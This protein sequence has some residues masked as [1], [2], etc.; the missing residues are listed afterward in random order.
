MKILQ[1]EKKKIIAEFLQL[2]QTKRYALYSIK[3]GICARYENNLSHGKYIFWNQTKQTLVSFVIFGMILFTRI[4]CARQMMTLGIFVLLVPGCLY[5]QEGKLVLKQAHLQRAA[6]CLSDT[7]WH[8]PLR[9]WA[10]RENKNNN[11]NNYI[12]NTY[13][14]L[15]LESHWWGD[16]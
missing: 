9:W 11:N 6:G 2:K 14:G 13:K 4:K 12:N 3:T 7:K 5:P 10:W 16:R 1:N 15:F 8:L